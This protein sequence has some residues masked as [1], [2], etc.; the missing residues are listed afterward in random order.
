MKSIIMT[1]FL[2]AVKLLPVVACT[3]FGVNLLWRVL[4]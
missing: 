3:Y 4:F 2:V 1:R